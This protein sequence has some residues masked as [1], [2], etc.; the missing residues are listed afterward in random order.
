MIPE[1]DIPG[2]GRWPVLR[3]FRPDEPLPSGDDDAGR[4]L[5]T[6]DGAAYQVPFDAERLDND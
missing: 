5:I 3:V 1:M 4:F 6:E 2:H